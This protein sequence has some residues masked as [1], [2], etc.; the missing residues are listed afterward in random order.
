MGRCA[1]RTLEFP[2]SWGTDKLSLHSDPTL[3]LFQQLSNLYA[4]ATKGKIGFGKT[5]LVVGREEEIIQAD[6]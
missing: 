5:S 6:S 3:E 2:E 4:I 1:C